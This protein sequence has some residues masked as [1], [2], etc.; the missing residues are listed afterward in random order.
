ML[1]MLFIYD[2]KDIFLS[3]WDDMWKAKREVG[4]HRYYVPHHMFYVIGS[5]AEWFEVFLL[6]EWRWF[7]ERY[8][9]REI[10]IFKL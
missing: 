5:L 8:S 6:K 1:I 9:K 10:E 4:V 2:N 7:A 3:I